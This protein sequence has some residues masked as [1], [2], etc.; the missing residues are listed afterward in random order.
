MVI[1]NIRP[2]QDPDFW[3]HLGA[4]RYMVVHRTIPTLDVFSLTARGTSWI[5]TYWLQEVLTYVFYLLGGLGGLILLKSLVVAFLAMG[6]GFCISDSECPWGSRLLAAVLIFLAGHPRGFGW[7]EKASL[8]TFGFLGLLY[9]TLQSSR[10][11]ER[12]PLM[13]IWPFLFS[14]WANMHRG[15]ILGLV[16][17][18]FYVAASWA[19]GDRNRGRLTAWLA[20][21]AAATLINPWGWRLYDMGWHDFKASP[22]QTMGWAYTPFFHLELFWLILAVYW[23]RLAS[24][25]WKRRSIPLDFFAVGM[26]LSW[27]SIRYASFYPYFIIWAV[28]WLLSGWARHP[29]VADNRKM[30]SVAVILAAAF[31][32]GFRPS[33]GINRSVFPTQAVAFMKENNLRSPF[34]HDFSAGGFFIWEF[35]G[36]PPVLIDGRLPA[37]AGY[38]QLYPQLEAIMQQTPEVFQRFF[39][40]HGLTMAVVNYPTTK[41]LPCPY[42]IY[43]PRSRWALVYWDDRVLIFVRR[44]RN[45]QSVIQKYEFTHVF[46]D[47]NPDFWFRKV[48]GPSSPAEK[49][50]IRAEFLSNLRLHPESQKARAWLAYTQ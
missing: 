10:W 21:C 15:F 48:W 30:T 19:R 41:F 36:N 43:F 2:I 11:P 28:T 18:S 49:S 32:F 22:T 5:N 40:R 1:F 46:P 12:P 9:Y 33:W 44:Q 6:M 31:T 20:L 29:L 23:V 35:N 37:V 38:R 16:L 4:G 39:N 7:S 3:W 45:Y 25:L 24:L 13:R 27:I 17:M 47:A 42:L 50:L 34:F 8:V 14:A 26:L